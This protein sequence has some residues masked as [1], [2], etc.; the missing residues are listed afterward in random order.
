MADHHHHHHHGPSEDDADLAQAGLDAA[1][2][3]LAQALRLSFRILTFIIVLLCLLFLLKGLFRVESHE[4]ALVLRFGQAR[5]DLVMD[6][7][8]HFAFPYPIDEVVHIEIRPK[9]MEVNTFWRKTTQ[10]EI[11]EALEKKQEAPKPIRGAENAYIITGDL[12]VLQARWDITYRIRG[13]EQSVL[14]YFSKIGGGKNETSLI[15]STVQSAAVREIGRVKVFDVY[16]GGKALTERVGS[17]LK[18]TMN[19]LDCGIEIDKVN[20]IDIRPPSA[21]KPSFDLVLET[22]EASSALRHEAEREARRI[23]IDAA[24]EIG[25]KLGKAVKEWWR[26]RDEGRTED[27]AGIEAEIS[28]LY[29]EAG[30]KVRTIMAT[31]RAYKTTVTE[32]AK[33]DADEITSLL[34]N[35]PMGIKIYLDHARIA[36]LQDVLMQAFEIFM[37]SP[38]GGEDGKTRPTLELLMNRRPEI[39]REQ[40][41]VPDSH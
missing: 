3:S 26:A 14:N 11:A 37:Y 19:D 15:E 5:P 16:P 40:T 21:V 13:D 38:A 8:L 25:E 22:E 17:V 2:E 28:G 41:R 9:K 18:K 24:G 29:A 20:L 34:A 12:N 7:G 33:G 36:A 30:G 35:T 23:L 31:A 27:M 39:L 1:G 32:N 4:K 6:E 10:L